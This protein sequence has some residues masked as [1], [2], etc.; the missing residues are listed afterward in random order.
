LENGSVTIPVYLQDFSKTADI[1]CAHAKRLKELLVETVAKNHP[2]YPSE[3]DEPKYVNCLNFLKC[4]LDSKG[5]VYT[6][7]YDLLL[8]WTLMY[9]MEKKL[10]VG[11]PNDGF[12]R[13]T[14]FYDGESH[15]SDYVTWQGDTN[16]HNQ[17]I[18][19]LH[20]ALHIFDRGPDVEK[21]VWHDKNVRLIDQSRQALEQGKF[22]L[23][24][25]EGESD[26]KMDK[27]THSGYLYHSYKSFSATMGAKPK[28]PNCL[29]TY[30]VSFTDNDWHIVKKI[31]EGRVKHLYVSIYGDPYSNDNQRIINYIEMLKRRRR[32]DE[33][34][35]TFYNAESAAV[36]G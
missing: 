26:K 25:S 8:Y 34:E 35:V 15:V 32:D 6:F 11:A 31:A 23:F 22:P 9:G 14:D 4:F 28:V 27:I 1:M 33:L 19:Y 17:N 29:F 12:G 10:I 21:F 5:R 13:D 2:E 16:A 3:I 7:N 18:H 30:G 24:V 36:W 20:G